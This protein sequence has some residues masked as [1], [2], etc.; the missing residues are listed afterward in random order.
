MAKLCQINRN[1][2]R[3]KLVAR[4]AA[5]R[6]ALKAKAEDKIGTLL[7][8]MEAQLAHGG[9]WA[10][11]RD[12]QRHRVDVQL[13]GPHA[14]AALADVG[15]YGRPQQS[16]GPRRLLRSLRLKNNPL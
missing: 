1:K 15:L 11:R 13:P 4:Y 5:K 9:L 2:K 16:R 8:Q 3:E 14:A 7:D 6:A 10:N 12:L